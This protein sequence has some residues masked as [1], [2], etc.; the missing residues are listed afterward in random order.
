MGSSSFIDNLDGIIK[1]NT[2]LDLII[3]GDSKLPSIIWGT[4]NT[5]V[6]TRPQYG[7]E[8]NEMCIWMADYYGLTQMVR[9]PARGQNVLDLVFS[10]YP[11]LVSGVRVDP[12][13]SDHEAVVFNYNKNI[14]SNKKL[15]G[16]A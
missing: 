14:D 1:D 2:L 6:V 13:I 4:D 8:L 5:H 10:I 9:E 16:R 12:G 3:A 15:V 11:G 7:Q